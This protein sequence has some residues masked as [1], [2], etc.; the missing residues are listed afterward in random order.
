MRGKVEKGALHEGVALERTDI[1]KSIRCTAMLC[2]GLW[3]F[4]VLDH[5]CSISP[6][7]T[8]INLQKSSAKDGQFSSIRGLGH[9]PF[10]EPPEGKLGI[11]G[12]ECCGE[13]MGN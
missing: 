7:T 13:A 10:F 8:A 11:D 2:V 1:D 4:C 6:Q 5:D 9:F 12:G 3:P